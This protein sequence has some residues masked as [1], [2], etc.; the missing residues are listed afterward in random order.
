MKVSVIIPVYNVE[1]Y[2]RECLDSV[3]AQSHDDI[4]VI[5]S[6]DGSTDASGTIC[7]EYAAADGRVRV[8]HAHN[9]GMSVARNRALATATGEC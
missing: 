7:D 8:I 4:E 9:G 2:L 6:D 5:L 3:L 1:A